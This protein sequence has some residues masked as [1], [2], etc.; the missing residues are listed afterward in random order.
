MLRGLCVWS[1]TVGRSV[2]PGEF[3][4]SFGDVKVEV[5]DKDNFSPTTQRRVPRR[6]DA[7]PAR[8]AAT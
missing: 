2:S 7:S 3:R 6:R 4:G 8:C 5:L 1:W